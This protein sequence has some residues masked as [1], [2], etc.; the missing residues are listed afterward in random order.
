MK[1]VVLGIECGLQNIG[2]DGLHMGVSTFIENC[3]CP[4]KVRI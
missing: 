4:T 1:M 2:I 3:G